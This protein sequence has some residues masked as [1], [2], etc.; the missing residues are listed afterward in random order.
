MKVTHTKKKQQLLEMEMEVLRS[1]YILTELGGSIHD[2]TT[3]T[4]AAGNPKLANKVC[5]SSYCLIQ[6]LGKA[7]SIGLLE[8][9]SRF[10]VL[11]K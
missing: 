2:C 5:D 8:V 1:H 11:V 10:W 6:A 3:L 4:A 9:G 7:L